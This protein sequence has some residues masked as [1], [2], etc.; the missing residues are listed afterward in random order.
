MVRISF[1]ATN[2]RSH[3]VLCWLVCQSTQTRFTLLTQIWWALSHLFMRFQTDLNCPQNKQC[4]IWAGSWNPACVDTPISV[5]TSVSPHLTHSRLCQCCTNRGVT[6]EAQDTWSTVCAE[7]GAV[8]RRTDKYKDRPTYKNKH[9]D[10]TRAGRGYQWLKMYQEMN[11]IRF[12]PSEQLYWQIIQWW[13]WQILKNKKTKNKTEWNPG[14][15]WKVVLRAFLHSL[16]L[17][18]L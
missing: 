13:S 14:D 4:H 8:S 10:T 6:H 11:N 17:I 3:S 12:I 2:N 16:A 1:S 15:L 9:I 18:L 5:G 7:Q